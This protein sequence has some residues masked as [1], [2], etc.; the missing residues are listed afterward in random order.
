LLEYDKV[1]NAEFGD[2]RVLGTHALPVGYVCRTPTHQERSQ[3]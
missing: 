2:D 3:G 1:T